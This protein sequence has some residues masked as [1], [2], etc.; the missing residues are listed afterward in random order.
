M[1]FN[2]T[3]TPPYIGLRAFSED[4]SVYFKGREEHILQITALLELNKFLM[5]TGASGDGKSSLVY[6][7]LVPNARAGFF[8]ARYPNWVVADFRPERSPLKNLSRSISKNLRIGNE[9]SVEVELLRGFSSLVEIY[10][11]SCLWVDET[12]NSW[13]QGNEEE[14]EEMQRKAANLLIVTDQF[15]EFFTNPENYY[16]NQPSADSQ[17]VI[18]LLLETARIA[19]EKDLPIYIVCTMR[20]DYVG[21]CASFRG[22]PEFIGFSQFFVPRLKRK[23]V[24][25]VVREPAL[26]HG[27]R[28]TNRLVE[29]VVYDLGEGIDQLPVLEHAMHEVWTQANYGK[30]EMDLLYYAMAG[31]MAA[32]DLPPAD[33]EKFEA[34]FRT[35][36]PSVQ[37]AY[38]EPGLSRIIDTHANKLF[39]SAAQR[40]ND[41]HTDK[42]S[43]EDAQLIIKIAFASL[44]KMDE[45]RAV[46][47]R[48][49]LQEITD[50]IDRPNLGREV[51]GGVLNIFRESGNTF[52]RPYISDDP[53][54]HELKPDS[55]LDI[56]HESLIRNWELLTSWATEE[57]ENLTVYEDFKKQLD[58][59]MESGKSSGFLLSIGQLTYFEAWYDKHRPNAFW[60]NRYLDPGIS[61]ALRMEEANST[62]EQ[63][64]EF[65]EKSARRHLITRMM[66]RHGAGKI[67][68]IAATI[69]VAIAAVYLVLDYRKK[70]NEN[71]VRQVIEETKP[72]LND[73]R[74]VA[75]NKAM[76]LVITEAIQPNSFKKTLAAMPADLQLG[77][78]SDVYTEFAWNALKEDIPM[79]TQILLYVD[80]MLN[81]T[82]TFT[83]PM[84]R[85]KFQNLQVARLTH[86]LYFI[87]NPQLEEALKRSL[88]DVRVLVMNAL[89]KDI[90]GPAPNMNLV[91][92]GLE[93]VL[94]NKTI[95]TEDIQQILASFSP[96]ESEEAKR[97]F[98][99]IC[100]VSKRVNYNRGAFFTHNGG[101]Q[102][103]AY[104][105]A[106]LGKIDRVKSCIDSLWKYN[107]RYYRFTNNP[108]MMG[109]Y[110]LRENH[111]AQLDEL[112]HY[113]A[114]KRKIPVT[115][116]YEQ[117]LNNSGLFDLDF[118]NKIWLGENHNILLSLQD[119]ATVRK[120][121]DL[122]EKEI[123]KDNRDQDRLHYNLALCYKH[124]AVILNRMQLE[125]RAST[126]PGEIKNLFDRSL[127]EYRNVDSRYLSGTMPVFIFGKYAIEPP[128]KDIY[129]YP[130]HAQKILSSSFLVKEYYSPAFLNYLIDN[131]H[132]SEL[133]PEPADV[134]R[135]RGWLERYWIEDMTSST[136]GV[137][138]NYTPL[139]ARDLERVDSLFSRVPNDKLAGMANHA[140]LLLIHEYLQSGQ[141]DKIEPV[142][143]KLDVNRFAENLA[144]NSFNATSFKYAVNTFSPLMNELAAWLASQGRLEEA[145]KI[146][147]QY[148]NRYNRVIAYADIARRYKQFPAK[149]STTVK[150]YFDSALN[151]SGK[152][153][154]F[155]FAAAD[156]R[157]IVAYS[158]S[159]EGD[160]KL[161]KASEDFVKQ[162]S[163][164]FQTDVVQ[165]WIHGIATSGKYYE[166][167]SSIPDISILS[168]RLMLYNLILI[169]DAIKVSDPKMKVFLELK[170]EL[171]YQEDYGYDVKVK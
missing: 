50:I 140:R 77:V 95:S 29:R 38:H 127:E 153:T 21:Q 110:L 66:V 118:S 157:I 55:V 129:L 163:I 124:R 47:N 117:W 111:M 144:T 132:F 34:W 137:E 90:D 94:N 10:Q 57:F 72:L 142:Y 27:D 45:G 120:I 4:D 63:S 136:L 116:G 87:K 162:V 49:T 86:H 113:Y 59:W 106:V 155:D 54:S 138:K 71:V 139:T 134:R 7:G 145:N 8:K 102:Q 114:E 91:N 89:I 149:P 32:K 151:V 33:R 3:D 170:K 1:I 96:F 115:E 107:T 98:N 70:Q 53:E 79:R 165:A 104:L 9:E 64:R 88:A 101:Y 166:A 143:A 2:P 68:G 58:R 171:F 83:E 24:I 42:I 82:K 51:V 35:L 61:P 43:D 133:Y 122:Y 150:S 37:G 17:L 119:E 75:A 39:L 112:M 161:L 123:R 105:Y 93:N 126:P 5:V 147:T 12:S 28:I 84:G 69:L 160:E 22:L 146:I 121:F 135:L 131:K 18:N 60:I 158:L 99:A 36:P 154:D 14:R 97:H 46:R 65:L 78:A 81:M 62:I 19:I 128:R 41:T 13:K 15:E 167:Y 125:G 73:P 52:L 76:T 44:T 26:L 169:N 108:T 164:N 40:Y 31:G 56:T 48:M 25:D 100:P 109:A 16:R 6:A 74:V 156:P 11:G 141:Y 20:S 92:D 152:I 168:D 23:E 30:E 85:L 103:V 130:D 148:S 159:E 67:I 80:S